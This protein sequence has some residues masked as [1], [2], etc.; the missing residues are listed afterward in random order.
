M[1]VGFVR[2]GGAG[3]I[4]ELGGAGGPHTLTLDVV[5]AGHA[6]GNTLV[7]CV[8]REGNGGTVSVSDSQGN[9][10]TMRKQGDGGSGRVEM[11]TAY[12]ATA[13]AD[14]DTVSVYVSETN[15]IEAQVQEFS[16]VSQSDPVDVSAAANGGFG[17][18]TG[19]AFA[20]LPT[21]GGAG[22]Y[23]VAC[24][25][26][27]HIEPSDVPALI[28]AWTEGQSTEWDYGT[29]T[30]MLR[31]AR[32]WPVAAGT[33]TVG[34]TVPTY[35]A[36]PVWG[37]LALALQSDT[38]GAPTAP[39]GL[40]ATAVS[41]SQINLAWS[42]NSSDESG[43]RIERSR[44]G[45]TFT[46]IATVGAGVE[47]YNDTGLTAATKYYY[48]VRAYNGTGNSAYTS[49]ASDTTDAT[50]SGG[51][52]EIPA[53]PSSCSAS[54]IGTTRIEVSW[55]DNAVDE[56]GFKIERSADGVNGWVQI[57]LAGPDIMS[58]TATGLQPSTTYYFRVRAYNEVG[59]S[60]YSNV[61]AGTTFDEG[62][63][64]AGDCPVERYASVGDV[65][66]LIWS[67]H[68]AISDGSEP[69]RAA[70]ED[71]LCDI[72]QWL[73][74]VLAWRYV[75]PVTD[76]RDREV[77]RPICAALV[78]ARCWQ[79]LV[80]RNPG[81]EARA[82]ELESEG[83]SRLVYNPGGIGSRL[84]GSVA[85]VVAN[86]GAIMGRAHLILPYTAETGRELGVARRVMHSFVPTEDR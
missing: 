21:T 38:A 31:V 42:D 35:V 85:V 11:W 46:E 52:T 66:R 13:L 69:N 30:D 9:V 37:V 58:L 41:S 77:L 7:V 15:S 28:A 83:L 26:Y 84:S 49:V 72:S 63:S 40:T 8:N 23:L 73:D 4:G 78:A 14:S 51:A 22:R 20:V 57:G 5:A 27:W 68:L 32:R 50:S 45:N 43:F 25:S 74:A 55:I 79:A 47:A 80:G 2:E 70:V 24:L 19:H 18:G 65:Q 61:A 81:Q 86:R 1:A 16:G 71:W 29:T 60:G 64:G 53:D 12:L 59:N 44:D 3:S 54:G 56:T 67:G 33:Y 75:V 34:W 10:Y 48:R 17:G 6:A 62:T 76:A 36:S 39:S 82:Q